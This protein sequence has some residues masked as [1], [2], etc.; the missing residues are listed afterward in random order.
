MYTKFED[1]V[2]LTQAFAKSY[3]AAVTASSEAAKAGSEAIAKT[4]VDQSNATVSRG[5]AV[6]KELGAVKT[7]DA[8]VKAQTKF[9]AESLDLAFVNGKALADLSGK[10][11]E[12]VTGPLA[13]H[14]KTVWEKFPKAA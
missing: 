14:A 6:A 12:D 3:T 8:L 13:A 9:A 7:P 1:V 5:I 10:V 11:A 2:A 4:L